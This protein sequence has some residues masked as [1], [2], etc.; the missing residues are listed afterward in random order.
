MGGSGSG[1]GGGTGQDQGSE[2]RTPEDQPAS[3]GSVYCE[4]HGVRTG[5]LRIYSAQHRL[6][7]NKEQEKLFPDTQNKGFVSA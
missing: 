2:T 3:M 4:D 7:E 6:H 5:L 1:T